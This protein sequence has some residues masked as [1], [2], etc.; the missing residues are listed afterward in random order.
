MFHKFSI[1]KGDIRFPL[2]NE[3]LPFYVIQNQYPGF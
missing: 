3:Y 1:K 2:E